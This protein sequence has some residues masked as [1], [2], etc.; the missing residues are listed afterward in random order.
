MNCLRCASPNPEGV[1]TCMNCGAPLSPAQLANSPYTNPYPP[2]YPNAFRNEAPK[3][4]SLNFLMIYIGWGVFV[5]MFWLLAQK[6]IIPSLLQNSRMDIYRIFY[7]LTSGGFAAISLIILIV[8]AIL[9]KTPKV[10]IFLII[11]AIMEL[12]IQAGF[13]LNSAL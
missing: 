9:S 8:F 12:V 2:Y 5:S 10:R 7:R 13:L 11:V 4:N 6:F 1:T 3:D